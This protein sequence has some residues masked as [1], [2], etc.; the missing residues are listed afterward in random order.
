VRPAAPRSR[1]RR[2]GSESV[3]ARVANPA[4]SGVEPPAGLPACSA[5]HR[6]LLWLLDAPLPGAPSYSFFLV[7]ELAAARP[8]G[9]GA[10]SR[11]PSY[12][13]RPA[14]LACCVCCSRP[15]SVSP[16]SRLAVSFPQFWASHR[17]TFV[18]QRGPSVFPFSRAASKLVDRA[19]RPALVDTL[20]RQLCLPGPAQRRPRPPV[21]GVVCGPEHQPRGAT[22]AVRPPAA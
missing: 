14:P 10:V 22:P 9:L 7:G 18:P 12:R 21:P 3:S 13:L 5:R 11:Q 16:S 15:R 4:S 19:P 8:G 6:T 20:T 2:R 17:L 1:R